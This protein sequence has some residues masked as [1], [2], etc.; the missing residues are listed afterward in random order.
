MSLFSLH[1]L[2]V[3]LMNGVRKQYDGAELPTTGKP[4]HPQGLTELLCFDY[5]GMVT[6]GANFVLLY[7]SLICDGDH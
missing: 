6:A 5:N 7:P 4:L 1:F 2:P 3:L